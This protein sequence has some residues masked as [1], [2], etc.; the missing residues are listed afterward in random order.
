MKYYILFSAF[1]LFVI[2][3]SA[4]RTF[5]AKVYQNT[6]YF[7]V[8][9]YN[10]QT[11][12]TTNSNNVNFSRISL[13]FAINTRK[14]FTHEFEILIPELSKSIYNVKLPLNY[15][16]QDD[17]ARE[18]T[19]NTYSLR[20]EL[21]KV[22]SD[23]FKKI[24]FNLGL[25]MNPYF[26]ETEYEP[27]ASYAYYTN[28][29]LFGVS[30]NLIPRINYNI[31]DR[32]LIDLNIPFKLYDL[33]FEDTRVNNPSLPIRQQSSNEFTDVFF[34]NAYTIRLGVSYVFE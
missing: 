12:S 24:R 9:Y 6:D 29:K 1:L 14:N 4:Q 23:P 33:Q 30:F 19:I 11:N 10:S 28:T 13:A 21:S 20:Y 5:Q 26:T 31:T 8:S 25:G 18:G 15:S 2:N 32:I 22:L 34:E 27:K 17:E 16:F 7:K 3:S